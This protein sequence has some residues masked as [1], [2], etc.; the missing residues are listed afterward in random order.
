MKK[1]TKKLG[2]SMC[3]TGSANRANDQMTNGRKE[4]EDD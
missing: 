1:V 4:G 3:Q 2:P